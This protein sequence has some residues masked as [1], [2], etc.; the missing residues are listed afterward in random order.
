MIK[1]KYHYYAYKVQ[2]VNMVKDF[3]KQN[4]YDGDL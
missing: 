1:N 2:I 4:I 3:L